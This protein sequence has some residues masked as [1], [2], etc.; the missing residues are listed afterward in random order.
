MTW[1]W[2]CV[3]IAF[4][5]MLGMACLATGDARPLGACALFL[6]TA[7]AIARL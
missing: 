6:L 4:F 7:F 3:L 2:A 1:P 5:L